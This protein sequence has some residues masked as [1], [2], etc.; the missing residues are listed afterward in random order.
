MVRQPQ[1][2]KSKGRSRRWVAWALVLWIFHFGLTTVWAQSSAPPF[3][4]KNLQGVTNLKNIRYASQFS[5]ADA[6]AK[7]AACIAD[8][9]TGGGTCVADF[10]G[11]QTIASN[12]FAGVTK[13]GVLELGSATYQVS[14]TLSI[15][16]GW[17]I[18]GTYAG[19]I[20]GLPDEPNAGTVFFWTGAPGQPAI[21]LFNAHHVSLRGFSIDCNY[22]ANSTAI[23]LDSSNDP[24]VHNID[25]RDFN[26]YRAMIGIQWGTGAL[27]DIPGYE[28][29]KIQISNGVIDSGLA[30]S[31]GI[32]VQGANKGQDS[33]IQAV[34]MVGV[35]TGI[36][37]SGSYSYL[38]I[39][40]C[41]IGVA[42]SSGHTDA[43]KSIGAANLGIQGR[44]R[45]R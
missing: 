6:G 17:S 7:I 28:V 25:I 37:L 41:S 31:K 44:S 26:I 36:D 32:V 30:G 16:S 35:D 4:V 45:E 38:D 42:G 40:D 14:A 2:S 27:P 10:T 29:D 43:I 24:P 3:K 21:R 8:L 13:P 20:W 12:P 11:T 5:G 33:K 19:K 1:T 39:E 15:P 18:L 22:T 34:T 23:L 9:P